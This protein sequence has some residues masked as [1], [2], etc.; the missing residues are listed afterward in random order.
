MQLADRRRVIVN[1]MA[2]EM[3]IQLRQISASATEAAMGRHRVTID[4][5]VAK[6]GGDTGPMGGELF[7]ASVGGC[8]MSTLLAAIKARGAEISHVRVEVV[9]ALVD[10]PVRFAALDLRVAAESRDPELLERLVGIADRGCIMMNTLRGALD[11]RVLI[12]AAV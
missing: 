3:K 12:A 7:L 1:V 9:G 8:F 10:S 11:V 5:P 6:G 2:S 4:R